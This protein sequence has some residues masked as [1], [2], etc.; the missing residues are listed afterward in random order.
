MEL[1]TAEA[2]AEAREAVESFIRRCEA[3]QGKFPAG[4]SQHSLLRNRL[5][6]LQ[7]SRALIEARLGG[8]DGATAEEL[9]AALPPVGSIL[10]K[11]RAAQAKYAPG[12]AQYDRFERMVRPMRLVKALIEEALAETGLS[13]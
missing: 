3:A 7:V 2:L 6:A 10:H 5:E 12:S 13:L 8:G 11:C 1:L 4:S 9:A